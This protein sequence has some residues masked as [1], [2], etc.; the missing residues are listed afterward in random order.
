MTY[1][2]YASSS[3]KRKDVLNKLIDKIGNFDGNPSS[4]HE[5]GRNANKYLEEARSKIAEYIGADP[6]DIFFTSGASESNNTILNAFD[7]EDYEIISSEIEHKSILEPLEK[8]SSKVLLLKADESG[9]I[10]IDD[11]KAKIT[12]NTK[13]VSLIYVNNET[14][15]I[16]PIK[17]V[18]EY[19]KD[20]NISFHVDAVQALGHID[21]NVSDINC[22]SLSLS[23]HKIGGLNGF[24]ILFSKN[25]IK[26]L[27]KGGNQEHGQRAG[28]SNLLAAMSMANSI[29][30]MEKEKKHIT[31][32]KKY[33][34]K[35][36]EDI[37]HEINGD[38]NESTNHIVN[39]Y[40]PF[41]KS[42]LLLTYLDMNE[43]Y[44]SAGS[45][46][47]AGTLEPS[48]VIESMHDKE[49][50]QH[51]IR[52]SFGFTNTK[53]DIDKVIKVLNEFY[54]RKSKV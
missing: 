54:S 8:S 28:T 49:R 25:I 9:K 35:K 44:A 43:V 45:A 48:Y 12:E 32:I 4:T 2:D 5:F 17:E 41:V 36:L 26:P 53:D 24:G 13:L 27:I 16:Q 47:L 14:G 37:P 6:K 42:D 3:I 31:E 29:E 7:C 11:L 40:F 52:F 30:Y 1:L 46:C 20:K 39:V 33:F 21:L 38:L 22:D 23:G 10:S 51:S 15:V 34:L 19:L 18:G 50:S